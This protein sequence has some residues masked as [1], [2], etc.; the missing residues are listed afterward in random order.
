MKLMNKKMVNLRFMIEKGLDINLG[1]RT[2]LWY[3]CDFLRNN[4]S[5][6]WIPFEKSSPVFEELLLDKDGNFNKQAYQILDLATPCFR[7]WQE[8][9]TRALS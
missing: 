8:Q 2:E 6:W 5:H 7:S 3:K 9:N 4:I 1:N